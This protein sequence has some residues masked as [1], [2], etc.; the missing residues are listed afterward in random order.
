MAKRILPKF[1]DI[2]A[3]YKKFGY[4]KPTIRLIL[5]GNADNEKYIEVRRYA[6]EELKC[7]YDEPT[8]F[9]G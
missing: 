2:E 7:R 5:M 1:G 3:L 9:E 4:S 8:V 6:V